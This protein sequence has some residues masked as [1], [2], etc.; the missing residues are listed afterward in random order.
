MTNNNIII[1]IIIVI[2]VLLVIMLTSPTCKEAVNGVL[3][4][5]SKVAPKK[6]A[7]PTARPKGKPLSSKDMGRQVAEKKQ[8]ENIGV[9]QMTRPKPAGGY[10]HNK[11]GRGLAS[12][13]LKRNAEGLLHHKKG[14]DYA[15]EDLKRN[16]QGLLHHNK[17]RD[18]A[19][20]VL[21]QDC[22]AV[23]N[24]F[25]KVGN[26]QVPAGV[27]VLKGPVEN[28][29]DPKIDVE[30]EFGISEAELVKMA[31][32][33]KKR[34]LTAE[35]PEVPRNRYVRRSQQDM[36]ETKMRESY[37]ASKKA[38]ASREKTEDLVIDAMKSHILSQK[39]ANGNDNSTAHQTRS[40]T[41]KPKSKKK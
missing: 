38:M 13:D 22:P 25:K 14:R 37:I 24:G 5:K 10:S 4:R 9:K 20:R 6:E 34:H 33:Y 36:A 7:P 2:I 8:Q 1:L 17:T 19:S 31:K 3:R 28:L 23:F 26:E 32:E 18:Y 40:H 35:K 39:R 16:A 30:G 29:F 41:F 21:E 12:D 27:P 11:K 15:S